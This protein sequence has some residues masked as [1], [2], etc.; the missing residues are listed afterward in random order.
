MLKAIKNLL[1]SFP[2]VID[3]KSNPFITISLYKST[4]ISIRVGKSRIRKGCPNKISIFNQIPYFPGQKT[5]LSPQKLTQT[6]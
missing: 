2:A 5:T 3:N 4:W 1:P 6:K